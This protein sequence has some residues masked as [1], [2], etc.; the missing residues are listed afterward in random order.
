MTDNELIEYIIH[1]PE[2]GIKQAIKQYGAIVNAVVIKII[3]ANNRMD[4]QECVSN[5]FIK[6]W[7]YSSQF[8]EEKGVLKGYIVAIA[9]NEALSKLK[10]IKKD[11][12]QQSLEEMDGDIGT[13]IDMI[14]ELSVKVNTEI[15]G[16]MVDHLKEPDR[17]IF[18]RRHYWGERIKIIA[19]AMN[20]E[21]KFV[22]NRLYLSK[23][24]L[25]KQLEEKGVVL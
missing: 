10:S 2:E 9:R 25:R 23:K 7:K 17:Q 5:V 1:N 19:A 20:L 24:L 14:S 22:E 3:G 12:M 6:L 21:E 18:I 4:V 16:E 8:D 13:D 11:N 15:I